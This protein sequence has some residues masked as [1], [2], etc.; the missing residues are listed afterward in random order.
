MENVCNKMHVYY[1]IPLIGTVRPGHMDVTE[2][3]D[4]H[5]TA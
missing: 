3:K 2:G 1:N 5:L 4:L